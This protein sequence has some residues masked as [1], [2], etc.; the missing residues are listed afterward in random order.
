MSAAERQSLRGC[1]AR[2]ESQG[3]LLRIAEPVDP[4]FEVSAVLEQ[5]WDGPAVLFDSLRSSELKL[6]GNVLN[7]EARFADALGV[8]RAGLQSRI[9]ESIEHPLPSRLVESGP[10]QEVAVEAP[11]LARLPIPYFFEGE[12]GP[13]I[14]AG[15]IV[16]ADSAGHA[17]N[18]SF[19]RLKPLG[20][21]RAFIG[22]APNHHLA[23]LARAAAGR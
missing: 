8:T 13:Y 23:Q 3:Q 2:L 15:A 11:D 10:C 22:I 7:S 14:T 21:N 4:R 5:I 19:A 12:T 9:V 16:A 6:I 17:R 20:G 1:L 18:L